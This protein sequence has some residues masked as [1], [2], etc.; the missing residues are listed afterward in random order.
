MSQQ[1]LVD[2]PETAREST[3]HC[4]NPTM[5]SNLLQETP[6]NPGTVPST[7][8][9]SPLARSILPDNN[10]HTVTDTSNPN[11]PVPISSQ[12]KQVE[13]ITPCMRQHDRCVD[14][15]GKPL[16]P[17]TVIFC[18]DLP[19]IISNNGKIY[20]YTGGNMKQ[21]YIADPSEHKLLVKEVNR[22]STFTNILHSVFG[23]LPGF[24][25]R[26]SQSYNTKDVE[27]QEQ[28]TPKASTIETIST[29]G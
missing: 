14:P 16:W 13:V 28:A 9:A 7:P 25:K 11:S 29:M 22:S 21:L 3:T 23:L 18:E 6:A 19:F 2:L 8:A 12:D 20:N 24:N 27:D 15:A 5:S 10:S 26:Q 17:G 1:D 4:C